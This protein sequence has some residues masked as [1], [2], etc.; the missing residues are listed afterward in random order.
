MRHKMKKF[1]AMMLVL[2]AMIP[3]VALVGC[4]ENQESQMVLDIL[5]A[6]GNNAWNIVFTKIHPAG[7]YTTDV[8][9]YKRQM[10]H[11][12]KALT[13]YLKGAV[14]E[15]VSEKEE[16]NWTF[17][18]YPV[19]NAVRVTL[20]ITLASSSRPPDIFPF[21][22]GFVTSGIADFIVGDV[23]NPQTGV[24][25]GR[26]VTIDFGPP[27]ASHWAQFGIDKGDFAS[28]TPETVSDP[29][30]IAPGTPGQIDFFEIFDSNYKHKMWTAVVETYT[31]TL[32]IGILDDGM[33]IYVR[34]VNPLPG[35]AE[36]EMGPELFD[37]YKTRKPETL[38]Q[39]VGVVPKNP[40]WVPYAKAI[41]EAVAQTMKLF[42]IK[43]HGFEEYTNKFPYGLLANAPGV[44]ID[45]P[46]MKTT[47]NEMIAMSTLKGKSFVIIHI[48]SCGSCKAK[49]YTIY[50]TLK[51]F[52]MKD[53][54]I[55]FL[56][57][58]PLDKL[59]DFPKLVGNS[60]IIID[61]E[62]INIT[63]LAFIGTPSLMA[64]D[65]QGRAIAQLDNLRL[66]DSE[67]NKILPMLLK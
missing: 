20:K 11:H 44:Y 39:I 60:P 52:G 61:E 10:E 2:L 9:I 21:L 13:E 6:I 43:N 56:S 34:Q 16:G 17:K 25:M 42:Y 36:V 57:K 53:S 48:S 67:I 22:Q 46:A 8:D 28:P 65:A 14:Y 64:V 58:S 19:E 59:E 18:G 27:P 12:G 63:R 45:I 50:A 15:V 54:Q 24:K 3:S 32:A 41:R 4:G 26:A 7:N 66:S 49:A 47:K 30:P 51:K 37:V 23:N 38:I 5:N 1:L 55:I 31:K 40:V 35:Q 33:V 29:D 62:Q